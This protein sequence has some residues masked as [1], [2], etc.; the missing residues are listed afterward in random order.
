MLAET[1][2]QKTIEV[3]RKLS[4]PIIYWDE[5]R[6]CEGEFGEKIAHAVASVFECGH[7]HVIIVGNDCPALSEALL[8]R[9]V[10]AVVYDGAVLG[11]DARGGAYVIGLSGQNFDP[12]EFRSLPWCTSALYEGLSRYFDLSSVV[13]LELRRDLNHFSEW[14]GIKLTSIAVIKFKRH[15]LALLAAYITEWIYIVSDFPIFGLK[16]YHNKGSPLRH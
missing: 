8:Q 7:S 6:Q 3:L 4:L 1:L 10:E 13:T 9:S 2:H 5:N 11:P 15:I 16:V 12:D 14:S